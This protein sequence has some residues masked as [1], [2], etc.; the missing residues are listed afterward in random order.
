MS[1]IMCPCGKNV[2][3]IH[4]TEIIDGAKKELHLC[5]EC[6]KEKKILFPS[7]NMLDLSDVLS[8][9]IDA[10]GHKKVDELDALRCPECGIT[11]ADFRGSGRFGCANDYEVFREGV[12]PLLE[13]MHGTTEHRGKVVTAVSVASTSPAAKLEELRSELQAAVADEAYERAARLRDQIYE[14]KKE[15]CDGAN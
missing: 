8:G 7:A 3:T 15:L 11:F 9:L 14:L 6:A 2:A 12:D 13:R 10:A 5:E 1:Q 4:V